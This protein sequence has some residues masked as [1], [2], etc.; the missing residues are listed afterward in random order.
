MPAA[1]ATTHAAHATHAATTHAAHA[2]HA[3]ATHHTA[4]AHAEA[5]SHDRDGREMQQAFQW[6]DVC[7]TCW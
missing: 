1:H 6:R 7:R 2:A 3:T 5:L 4:T